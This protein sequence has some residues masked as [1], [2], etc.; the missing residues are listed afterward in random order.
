[1]PDQK[2]T[3]SGGL[4]GKMFVGK[5]LRYGLATV[6][7]VAT[8]GA[9]FLLSLEMLHALDP[10][11]FGSFSFLLVSSQF[12]WGVWSALFCAPL[13]IL[14]ATGAEAEKQAMLRCLFSA[15]GAG[16]VFASLLFWLLGSSLGIPPAAAIVF[17]IYAAAALVR[18]FARQHAYLTGSACR[19][20]LSD[21]V[22][23]VVLLGGIVFVRFLGVSSLAA[24]FAVLLASALVSLAPFGLAYI[25]HQFL[26]ISPRDLAQY[27]AIWRRY[28]SWSLMGVA[29]T[30]ATAN[31]HAYIVTFFVGPSAFAPLSASALL[32]RPIGVVMTALTDFERPQLALQIQSNQLNSA[33]RSLRIFRFALIG[34]WTTTA[35]SAVTLMTYAPRLIFPPRY[36]I[37]YLCEGAAI[38]MAIA[39]V[40]LLRTPE[41]ALLQAAGMFRPLAVASV[42]SSGVSVAFVAILLAVG[43]PL[44]SVLG[45]LIGEATYALWIRRQAHLWMKSRQVLD[46]GTAFSAAKPDAA[47]LALPPLLKR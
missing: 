8:A 2:F 36:S 18:W 10:R 37:E 30:E 44:L 32:I 38:W 29:T 4:A 9:Q 23:S 19:T 25:A 46:L 11:A 24:S 26:E 35:I 7:P 34:A 14:V 47:L 13:P 21:L 3:R 15:N 39:A 12:S 20:V 41:S 1:M 17:A 16:A 42:I 28:S 40:R 31:A 45:I 33:E 6:G 22:Y 43:G 27:A 5:V